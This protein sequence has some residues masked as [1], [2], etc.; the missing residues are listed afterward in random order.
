MHC[1][2]V[3]CI[4]SV[5]VAVPGVGCL[6][7]GVSAA[8]GYLLRGCLPGGRV[9]APGADPGGPGGPGPSLTLGFEAPKLSNFGPYLTFP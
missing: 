8:G 6:P 9:S 2:P 3:G 5:A 1:V 7:R 4:P